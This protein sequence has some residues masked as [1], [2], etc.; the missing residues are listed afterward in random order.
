MRL[1][2]RRAAR[3]RGGGHRAGADRLLL[4]RHDLGLD[5]GGRHERAGDGRLLARLAAGGLPRHPVGEGA[6]LRRVGAQGLHRARQGRGDRAHVRRA[7]RPADRRRAADPD[8]PDRLRHG[9]RAG[10]LL[11]QRVHAGPHDRQARADRD[12]AAGLHR[13]GR[14]RRPPLRRRRDHRPAARRADPRATAA[15]TTSSASTSCCRRSSSPRTS[16]AG[17]TG[18]WA[19]SPRAARPS[20]A[21]SSSS[22]AARSAR[23]AIA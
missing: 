11:R 10:R 2:D 23:S 14:G 8:R 19:C 15:S 9:P 3:V 21:S 5:V 16:R 22:R 13:V 18:R 17:T 1:A 20:R 4:R 6:A 12:R 7:L